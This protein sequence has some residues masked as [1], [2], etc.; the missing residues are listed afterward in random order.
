[1]VNNGKL[2]F[3]EVGSSKHAVGQFRSE[4]EEFVNISRGRREIVAKQD[5]IGTMVNTNQ[6]EDLEWED[7]NG[8][9]D[10]EI[11]P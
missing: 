9:I 6:R 1:M 3:N 11:V 10:P 8:N 7:E 5:R 2:E 4:L